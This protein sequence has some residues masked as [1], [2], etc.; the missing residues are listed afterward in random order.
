MT[1]GRDKPYMWYLRDKDNVVRHGKFRNLAIQMLVQ[2][3]P[4][5]LMLPILLHVRLQN[6]H[7]QRTLA[8]P[9]KQ[10]RVMDYE[11]RAKVQILTL[12]P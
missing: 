1:R 12:S 2:L 9:V 3:I 10:F 5:L 4:D 11:S 6:H 8:P 7:Y